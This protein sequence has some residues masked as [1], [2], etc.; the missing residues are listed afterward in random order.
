MQVE[1]RFAVFGCCKRPLQPRVKSM[2][3]FT[4]EMTVFLQN[5]GSIDRDAAYASIGSARLFS[6]ANKL[7]RLRIYIGGNSRSLLFLQS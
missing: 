3:R 1:N 4:L 2:N 7:T 5:R 6:L